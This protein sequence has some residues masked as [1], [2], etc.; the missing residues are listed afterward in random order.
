MLSPDERKEVERCRKLF[1]RG[2][3]PEVEVVYLLGGVA[4]PHNLDAVLAEIP[5]A[6]AGRLEA[7][8]GDFRPMSAVGYWCSIG[9]PASRP[10]FRRPSDSL[11]PDPRRLVGVEL[12][13]AELRSV[14]DYL[15]SGYTYCQWRGLSYCRFRCGAGPILMGSQCLS[16][17]AWVWPEGLSHYVEAHSV[18]L[19]E[20]FVQA[21]L[22][23]KSGSSSPL[24]GPTYRSQG[25]PDYDF[26]INWGRA[27]GATRS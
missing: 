19:P 5:Q 1:E 23:G 25:E 26:W 24:S 27:A 6:L 10:S 18:R 16:D 20:E 9:W 15:R 8:T 22:S 3:L 13:I 17:G 4:R 11:F 21:A 12:G 2:I 14:I 7:Q